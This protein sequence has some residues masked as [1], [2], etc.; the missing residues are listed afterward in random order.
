M[1][2]ALTNLL[3]FIVAISVLVAVHEYG[4]YIVGRWCGMKVL[5]FSI[6]FGKPLW[7][8]VGGK[9][10]TEYCISAIPLGGY[11]KFLGE[12]YG[13]GEPIDPADEGRAFN[14]RPIWNRI[15]VLLAGP[16]FNFLFAFFAYWVLFING[17]PTMKPAVGEVTEASYAAEAGL[18][19]GDRII[20]VGDR[21]ATDWET[22]LVS[23]LDEMVSAGT[24]TLQLEETDG[25]VRTTTINVGDD[26][27]RL[28]EPGMLFDG[29][30]FQPWRPPAVLA[31][32]E[33]GGAGHSG[34][35]EVGDQ[36]TS[37]DGEPVRSFGDLQQIVSA[38]PDETVAI[39]LLRNDEP[40][41]IDLTIG[42]R[43][44]DGQASGFLN[45][46]IGNVVDD[47]WYMRQ[48][49]PL[50]SIGQS[51][52]RTWSSTMF[53]LRMLG[54]M[55]TGEVSIK[56]ISGPINIAQFAGSS[57]AAGI[58]PFLNFLALVSISL[59]VLNL[60]PVPVLDGGQ[61]VYHSI[62]GIK[63]S[64]LSE[65][66]QLIGQQVGILALLLLMSFAFYNDI[67]RILN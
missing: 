6:G 40:L 54:R 66:A 64:P 52:E 67:A 65:R 28:T 5:R 30:G 23:M 32:V 58:N 27:T 61:I 45:V 29:L 7:M 55:V 35:L 51:I 1:I 12:R 62:E 17:V 38:R 33:E 63:G 36:I 39:E 50:Q 2:A 8:R 41:V 19:Y 44:T 13:S 57:A 24:V 18:I 59:G 15:L 22:A 34:G 47:Y 42:S 48:F 14:H 4:H 31:S 20:K 37:I 25:F 10:Q 53:T 9:D 43:D 21:D 60:L 16:F 49:G 3:A 11:V 56:N 26:R 46:G